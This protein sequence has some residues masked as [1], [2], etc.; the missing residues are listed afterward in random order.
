MQDSYEGSRRKTGMRLGRSRSNNYEA[1]N[2][3]KLS[4]AQSRKSHSPA[5]KNKPC[6]SHIFVLQPLSR[7]HHVYYRDGLT[8]HFTHED[9]ACRPYPVFLKEFKDR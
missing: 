3:T 4:N 7:D 2:N 9:K 5:L 6:D 1:I 8:F